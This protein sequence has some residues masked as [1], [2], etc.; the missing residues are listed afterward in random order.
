MPSIP[1]A[2]VFVTP[3][4]TQSLLLEINRTKITIKKQQI[5]CLSSTGVEEAART[6][7]FLVTAGY[8]KVSVLNGGLSAWQSEGLPTS[9][10]ELFVRNSESF[11]GYFMRRNSGGKAK[12]AKGLESEM[13]LLST[14]P[15]DELISDL[16]TPDGLLKPCEELVSHLTDSAVRL[17][18]EV[19]TVVTG[20]QAGTLLLA[21][22]V[23]GL[24]RLALFEV[25]TDDGFSR[26]Q[27]KA[28]ISGF[29]SVK[30]EPL[31]SYQE[32]TMDF[33]TPIS[34][35][36]IDVTNGGQNYTVLKVP[37]D[38]SKHSSSISRE[39][40]CACLRGCLIA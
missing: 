4:D 38:S 33:M 26:M 13:Q 8:R 1:G 19:T 21:L 30:D 7:W 15:G 10:I 31:T 40:T 18:D 37:S 20:E 29:C 12:E 22:K 36:E 3:T 6:L 28:T 39:S 9:H 16:L 14:L 23:V 35:T 27:S 32:V 34:F 5:I 25:D 11:Q 24:N 2:L 17:D